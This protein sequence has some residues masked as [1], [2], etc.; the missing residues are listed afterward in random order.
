MPGVENNRIKAGSVGLIVAD[1]PQRFTE[2]ANS[3]A[4]ILTSRISQE[5]FSCA[6]NV[7]FC[8]LRNVLPFRRGRGQQDIFVLSLHKSAYIILILDIVVRDRPP[9]NVLPPLPG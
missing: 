3:L 8:L 5:R 1:R 2:E 9:S 6:G 7:L 4:Y